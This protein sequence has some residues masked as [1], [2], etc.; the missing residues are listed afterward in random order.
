LSDEERIARLTELAR[1]VFGD[2]RVIVRNHSASVADDFGDGDTGTE[3]I[4]VKHPRALDALEA[5]LSVLAGEDGEQ[6]ARERAAF[7]M[8]L[9]EAEHTNHALRESVKQ[10][11]ARACVLEEILSIVRD[12]AAP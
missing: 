5:A 12:G 1:K 7:T 6:L 10:W 2:S 9:V 11:Q 4:F 8:R 3:R